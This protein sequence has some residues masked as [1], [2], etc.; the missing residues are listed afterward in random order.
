MIP[1]RRRA[2]MA[3]GLALAILG[4]A[5]PLLPDN[6]RMPGNIRLAHTIEIGVSNFIFGVILACQFSPR[7]SPTTI[8]AICPT[9]AALI[10]EWGPPVTRAGQSL[11]PPGARQMP[12]VC[13]SS[14]ERRPGRLKPQVGA[15]SP[16][17]FARLLVN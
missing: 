10:K 3:I 1:E 9:E 4:G 5:V 11:A 17:Q 2:A 12:V 14:R 6:P 13:P 16:Q 7:S 8:P 15:S